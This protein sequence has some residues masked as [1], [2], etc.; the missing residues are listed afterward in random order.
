MEIVATQFVRGHRPRVSN[1]CAV[2]ED[3]TLLGSKSLN[4][5]AL[6][7]CADKPLLSSS[8]HL[9][10]INSPFFKTHTNSVGRL[11]GS[12]T[13]YIFFQPPAAICTQMVQ[14]LFQLEASPTSNESPSTVTRG[15]LN[16][17]GSC[18]G[19][20]TSSKTSSATSNE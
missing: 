14:E 18:G 8:G 15:K 4:C 20:A 11:I 6:G 16:A 10:M 5:L 7:S 13:V 9:S 1:R 2:E 19:K 12:L 17:T 3:E